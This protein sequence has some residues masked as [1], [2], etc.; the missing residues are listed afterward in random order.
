MGAILVPLAILSWIAVF[1]LGRATARRKPLPRMP[2]ALPTVPTAPPPARGLATYL[3][4]HGYRPRT[5]FTI[6]RLP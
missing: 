4:R 5:R 3:R 6:R 1:N 2:L